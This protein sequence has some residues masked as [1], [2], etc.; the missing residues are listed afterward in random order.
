MREAKNTSVGPERGWPMCL[1]DAKRKQ[2]SLGIV[3][4][5]TIAERIQVGMGGC[6]IRI[7]IGG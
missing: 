2:T 5:T 6:T 7:V 3:V 1:F 4:V